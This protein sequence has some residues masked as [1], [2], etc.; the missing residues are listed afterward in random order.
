MY[1]GVKI[2]HEAAAGHLFKEQEADSALRARLRRTA[3]P[4]MITTIIGDDDDD[5]HF[6]HHGDD[7]RQVDGD[8]HH[9]RRHE[10]RLISGDSCQQ[11]PPTTSAKNAFALKNYLI[12]LIF[13][14][15]Q[16]TPN[17]A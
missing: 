17:L 1:S 16:D 10:A 15:I 7:D 4:V 12:S 8:D 6:G 11:Y 3:Q 2:G 9:Q 5:R 13:G 14:G